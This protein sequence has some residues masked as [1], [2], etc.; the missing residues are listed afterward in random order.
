MTT[1]LAFFV[2][3]YLGSNAGKA[4]LTE[5]VDSIDTI[6]SS[7]EVKDLI[8]GGIAIAKDLIRKGGETLAERMSSR[9]EGLTIRRIA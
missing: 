4:G 8:E 2:G 7:Q 3:F 6:R 5:V 9:D 1:L